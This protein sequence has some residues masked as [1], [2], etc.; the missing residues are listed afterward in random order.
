MIAPKPNTNE[1]LEY[2]Y[3]YFLDF[4]INVVFDSVYCAYLG[5]KQWWGLT[6]VLGPI[7]TD[8]VPIGN[9]IFFLKIVS[10]GQIRES[11]Y[12]LLNLKTSWTS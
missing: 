1:I 2:K 7:W 12:K 8:L 9:V 4:A 6:V 3:I 5:S 11:R 10:Y